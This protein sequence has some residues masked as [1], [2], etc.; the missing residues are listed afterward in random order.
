[1][2]LRSDR[3]PSGVLMS[4]QQARRARQEPRGPIALT[5]ASPGTPLAERTVKSARRVLEVL[6]L[7]AERRGP[8]TVGEV[9]AAL[10]YPQSSASVLLQSLVALGYLVHDR[11]QRTFLP[12]LRVA[13][14][15]DWLEGKE[16]AT[17]AIA[18]LMRR[19]HGATGETIILGQRQGVHVLYIRIL[20][21]ANPVRFVLHRGMRRPIH[22]AATGVALLA[23][24]PDR[25]ILAILR[26]CNAEA[27]DPAQRVKAAVLMAGI[28]QCRRD[29]YA[30]SEGSVTPGAGVI[31][32]A[33]PGL[34]PVPA[35]ALGIGAPVERLKPHADAIAARLRA[36]IARWQVEG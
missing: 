32:M 26:R 16:V 22:Q 28:A 25:E 30:M 33:L 12:T 9:A 14:L 6:E 2:A 23:G 35:T 24:L 15:G 5:E 36:E 7:F 18:R 1:M 31:A 21:A 19:L 11:G 20:E 27:R 8:L 3:A 4:R 29:G 10:A 34:E 17:D 13:F